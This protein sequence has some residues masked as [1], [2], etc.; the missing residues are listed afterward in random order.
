V[1]AVQG[2]MSV[3]EGL[4]A[5]KAGVEL[6]KRLMDVLNRPDVDVN[7][8]RGKLQEM[9]IHVVNAQLALGDAQIEISELRHRLDE[10]DALK[11]LQ[12]DMDFQIDGGFYIRKSEADKG[13]IAYCPLCWHK[14]HNTVPL[15]THD[16]RGFFRCSIHGSI[17]RT[18]ECRERERQ[19]QAPGEPGSPW[20]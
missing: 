6:A 12:D 15:A 9:L 18:K 11:A 10:R 1:E 2:D 3:V 20:S 16:T 14:D 4:T 7:E 17:Y 13:L 19:R 5:A 8:V